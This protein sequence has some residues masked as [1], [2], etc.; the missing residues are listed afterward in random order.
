VPAAARAQERGESRLILS[1]IGGVNTGRT[2]WEI[3]RQ[4]LLVL[5]TELAPRYDTLR[6]TRSVGTGIV[7]GVSATVFQ[8]ANVGVSGEIV[9]LGL[10]TDDQCTMVYENAGADPLSRNDQLCDNIARQSVSPNTVGFFAGAVYRM[11]PRAFA[12]PYLRAQLGVTTRSGS[13]LETTGSYVEPAGV[14]NRSVITDPASF[15]VLPSLGAAAGVMIPLG[16][17]YQAR[18]ELRDQMVLM[19]Q[20][21]GPANNLTIAPSR[22]TLMHSLGLTMAVD[23][24]LEQRRGRRY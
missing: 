18:L 22:R 3:N 21:T 7:L 20:A 19:D 13:T 14:R 1:V 24:V 23:I 4:P 9:F 16:P 2:L 17:G 5:G 8:S 12:S 15:R 10:A 6:L 11:A